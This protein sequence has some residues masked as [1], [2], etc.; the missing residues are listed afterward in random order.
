MSPGPNCHAGRTEGLRR[1]EF[2]CFDD[3]GVAGQ[4]SCCFVA[5]ATGQSRLQGISMGVSGWRVVRRSVCPSPLSLKGFLLC[6]AFT[7]VELKAVR[8]ALP[9][10]HLSPSSTPSNTYGPSS[11]MGARHLAACA[12]I[13]RIIPLSPSRC[14]LASCSTRVHASEVH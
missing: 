8:P 6:S 4:R 11:Y 13:G 2:G 10:Y 12:M 14:L 5:Q 3:L 1:H 9:L 7:H